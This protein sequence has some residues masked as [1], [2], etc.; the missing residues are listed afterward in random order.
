MNEIQI[1]NH[2]E[3][4][5]VRTVEI[6]GQIYSVGTDVAKALQYKDPSRAI[7]QNVDEEDR[8]LLS[9]KFCREFLIGRNTLLENIP[10]RGLT[11]I[12]ESG[13]YSLVLASKLQGAKKFKHWV[14]SEVLPTIRKTGSYNPNSYISEKHRKKAI[15][16]SGKVC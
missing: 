3:F 15:D 5:E 1:F 4:G 11:I 7:R 10:N 12:N 13:L 9:K 16:K 8:M 14:T 2:E 6:D